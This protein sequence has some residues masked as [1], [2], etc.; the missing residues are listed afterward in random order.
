M[1][2]FPFMNVESTYFLF[3]LTLPNRTGLNF[4]YYWKILRLQKNVTEFS[5]HEL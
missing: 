5:E 2:I 3:S 4:A 1:K